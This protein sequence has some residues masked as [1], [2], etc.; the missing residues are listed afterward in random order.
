MS[1]GPAST[2]EDS[3]APN[4]VAITDVQYGRIAYIIVTSVA[5]SVSATAVVQELL[6]ASNP[7]VSA[8]QQG[9]L[10]A[11]SQ[12]ALQSDFVRV[13]I[14]GGSSST[15]VTV[16]DLATLRNYIEQ[17]RP[18]VGGSNAV[19]IRYTLRYARDN[20][21]AFIGAI[22]NYND[23]ECARAS[24]LRVKL[25]NITPTKV[26]DFGDE[27][28]YGQIHVKTGAG[29]DAQT[30]GVLWSV[31]ASSAVQGRQ[32]TAISINEELFFNL[33]PLDAPT[34]SS[35]KLEFTVRDRIMG[36]EWVGANQFGKDNGY[37]FYGPDEG[38]I[39]LQDVRN[40]PNSTLSKSYTL[41]ENNAD[42]TV[43]LNFDFE[44]LSVR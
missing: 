14:I 3:I 2:V 21:T 11:S 39:S 10:S 26:V 1:A 20:A 31:A 44:L 18:T 28:L 34:P 19:P 12:F 35:V 16:R 40:A 37:V 38:S 43:R 5:S 8:S 6:A 23:R 7:L 9:Q 13:K 33:N 22:A 24:Q 32:N 36:E 4:I 25:K 29:V 41:T 30:T 17:I 42:A 15:A 27:E